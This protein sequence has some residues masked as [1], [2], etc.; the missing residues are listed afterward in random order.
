MVSRA[1]NTFPIFS[2]YLKDRVIL[3]PPLPHGTGTH[4][5]MHH[6][7]IFRREGTKGLFV[8]TR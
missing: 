1:Q 5:Q 7:S 8:E 2:S 3:L 4:T 6:I